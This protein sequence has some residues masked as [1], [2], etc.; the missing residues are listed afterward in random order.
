MIIAVIIVAAS[1]LLGGVFAEK[2]RER[3]ITLE[4]LNYGAARLKSALALQ[5][6]PLAEA[7]RT[8]SV[9]Q[10]EVL[11]KCSADSEI[12]GEKS[13]AMLKKEE[14]SALFALWERLPTSMTAEDITA[15]INVFAGRINE[16]LEQCREQEAKRIKTTK[17]LCVLGGLAVAILV[18]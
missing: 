12:A 16:L 5:K 18:I 3:K 2:I 7:L 1:A 15:A 13:I 8:T 9:A 11:A 4:Q 10:F 17:N 14:K 6:L